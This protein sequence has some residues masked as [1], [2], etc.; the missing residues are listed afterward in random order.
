MTYGPSV[1]AIGSE[2]ELCDSC[3]LGISVES[4]E[5]EQAP[6]AH[7]KQGDVLSDAMHCR[8]QLARSGWALF[9]VCLVMEEP[10]CTN[11]PTPE[12]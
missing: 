2:V 9:V 4:I 11:V 8:I 10:F 6:Y 12:L 3:V 7:E 5:R 1:N